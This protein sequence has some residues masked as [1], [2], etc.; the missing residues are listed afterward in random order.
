MNLIQLTN[1]QSLDVFYKFLSILLALIV[2]FYNN[3][4]VYYKIAQSNIVIIN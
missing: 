1:N 4:T 2:N 3:R